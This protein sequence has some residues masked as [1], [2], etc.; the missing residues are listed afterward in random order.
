MALYLQVRANSPIRFAEWS[1]EWSDDIYYDIT[2]CVLCVLCHASSLL[3]DKFII[4][5]ALVEI[6]KNIAHLRP[7]FPYSTHACEITYLYN[8]T[9]RGISKSS[10]FSPCKVFPRLRSNFT[11]PVAHPSIHTRCL[12]SC[13][14]L[15]LVISRIDYANS[16]LYQRAKLA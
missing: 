15:S 3:E 6:R 5:R 7:I 4:T 13:C 8:H 11:E 10:V 1:G 12:S 9:P 16:M 14:Q 2:T